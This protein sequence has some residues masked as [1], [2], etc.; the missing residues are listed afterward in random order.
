MRRAPAQ[1]QIMLSSWNHL[2][3]FEKPVRFNGGSNLSEPSTLDVVMRQNEPLDA[4]QLCQ[5]PGLKG[6]TTRRVRRFAVGNFVDVTETGA[7]PMIEARR[8]RPRSGFTFGFRAVMAHARPS[9]DKRTDQPRPNR[10][11]M[12]GGVAFTWR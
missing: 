5:L 9:L 10:A 12:M 2:P 7:E 4:Q 11:L 8:G 6:T 1:V 3:S